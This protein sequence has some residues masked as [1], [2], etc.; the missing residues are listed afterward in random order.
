MSDKEQI[1]EYAEKIIKLAQDTI[2]V[3]FRFL[4]SALAK[5][6]P[7][8][9]PG[10]CGFA[11]DGEKLYYDPVV[12]LREY[13]EEPN[14][15][16]R[17]YLHVLLHCIFL[18]RERKDK[19]NERYWNLA[20]DIAVEN[21]I[22]ELEMPSASLSRDDEAIYMIHRLRKNVKK[23]TA[24]H[25]YR[26]FMVHGLSEENEDNLKRLFTIDFH[27]SWRKTEVTEEYIVTEE[28]WKE[29]ARRIKTDIGSFSKGKTTSEGLANS[30]D[31]ATRERYD[32]RKILQRFMVSGEELT[33]NDDE[34]DYI[35]Y[36]YGLAHY[37]NLPLVEPLE[38][39]E[40]NRIK[41]FVIAIDT[42]ASCNGDIVKQFVQKTYEILKD[43]E[44]FFHQINVHVIQCDNEIKQDTRITNESEFRDFIDNGQIVGFGSTDFRPVFEYVDTLRESGELTNLKGLIYFTDGYGIYPERMPEYDVIFAF[45]NEDEHRQ[46]VPGWAIKVIMED[47]INEYK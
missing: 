34:F 20:A 18:H 29:I 31:E 46:E 47:E 21:T 44:N 43:G 25:L 19:V 26:D 35:Y 6:K 22:L 14:I 23:I 3:R 42:S 16:V 5:L 15:A 30:I 10:L 8:A 41:E 11:T 24:E 37:G 33:V 36:T 32:Y 17:M 9:K 12:L 40:I 27:D 7:E 1:I 38:Y 4:D 2:I 45:L 13:L 39:K 28:Q